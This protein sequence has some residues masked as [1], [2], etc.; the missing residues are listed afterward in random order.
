MKWIIIGLNTTI[1]SDGERIDPIVINVRIEQFRP[2]ATLWKTELIVKERIVA[3][4]GNDH[5][6]LTLPVNPTMERD[7]AVG[8]ARIERIDVLATQGGLVP[9]EADQ[10]LRES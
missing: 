4:T 10:V 8:V 5:N 2:V 6:I 9:A 1:V 7:Y 3:E